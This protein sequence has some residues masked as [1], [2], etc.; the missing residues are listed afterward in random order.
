M[1]KAWKG[2]GVS[3]CPPSLSSFS[4]LP[5]IFSIAHLDP[6]AKQ[7]LLVSFLPLTLQSCRLGCEDVRV[8]GVAGK[9]Q[10]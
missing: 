1:K 6:L 8:G 4:R 2:C 10:G 3:L 5:L 7:C 9:N